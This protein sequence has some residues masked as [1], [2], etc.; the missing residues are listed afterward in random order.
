MKE[1]IWKTSNLFCPV[2]WCSSYLFP[3]SVDFLWTNLVNCVPRSPKLRLILVIFAICYFWPQ[4]GDPGENGNS[5]VGQLRMIMDSSQ[6]DVPNNING[7]LW[8]VNMN[9][10]IN[11]NLNHE[12]QYQYESISLNY[13][14][15]VVTA[16]WSDNKWPTYVWLARHHR[17]QNHLPQSQRLSALG[18]S[19]PMFSGA[20]C[21]VEKLGNHVT[22]SVEE[23]L[24]R[25]CIPVHVTIVSFP[26]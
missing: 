17:L 2:L 20:C 18:N 24:H 8:K 21:H 11:M 14:L 13:L 1:R 15:P 4:A 5:Q 26:E 10:N 22:S 25:K 3:F 23:L 16:A 9:I 19:A 12:C 7:C 6:S